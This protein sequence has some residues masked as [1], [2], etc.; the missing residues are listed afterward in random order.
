MNHCITCGKPFGP[1]KRRHARTCS[2][3]CRQVQ[4]R[5]RKG[6]KPLDL[7]AAD[8]YEIAELK[9]QAAAFAALLEK[10]LAQR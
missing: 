1:R 5:R 3:S 7:E 2:P 8:R 4:V 10:Q 6:I 9:L